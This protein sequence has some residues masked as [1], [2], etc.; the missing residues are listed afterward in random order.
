MTALPNTHGLQLDGSKPR[1]GYSKWRVW[2]GT[3]KNEELRILD[4]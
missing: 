3:I 2:E 1:V 4:S